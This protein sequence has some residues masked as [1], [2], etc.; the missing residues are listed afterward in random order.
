MTDGFM[1]VPI[2][3]GLVYFLFKYATESRDL[4]YIEKFL[5]EDP[6]KEILWSMNPNEELG[7]WSKVIFNSASPYI[8]VTQK[9]YYR[10]TS[11]F[12][13]DLDS[14]NDTARLEFIHH[15]SVDD[16]PY[17]FNQ[18]YV[19]TDEES[20][21]RLVTK[22]LRAN[23][24]YSIKRGYSWN[25][26]DSLIHEREGCFAI[27]LSDDLLMLMHELIPDIEEEEKDDRVFRSSA[28]YRFMLLPSD[29]P[30]VS[31]VVLRIGYE[32]GV[33][34]QLPVKQFV[35]VVKCLEIE[36]AEIPN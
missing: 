4:D 24:R 20:P 31:V 26:F 9:S 15:V 1:Y 19:R 29:S 22:D 32:R 11:K 30:G 2:V 12:P 5:P 23:I 6:Y 33:R 25:L 13:R 7:A 18:L 10:I 16:R 36:L 35:D 3:V 14:D 34:F 28:N 27:P 21:M 8:P 17:V